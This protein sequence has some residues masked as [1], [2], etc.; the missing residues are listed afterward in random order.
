MLHYLVVPAGAAALAAC[1][2]DGTAEQADGGLLGAGATDGAA[3][4]DV[5]VVQLRVRGGQLEERRGAAPAERP[6]AARGRRADESGAARIEGVQHGHR[7]EGAAASHA[8]TQH[9]AEVRGDGA[10]QVQRRRQLQPRGEPRVLVA[11]FSLGG[12]GGRRQQTARRA[13]HEGAPQQRRQ[14]GA[15][16]ALPAAPEGG[17]GGG[18]GLGSRAEAGQRR[19]AEP[20]R[21]PAAER[22]PI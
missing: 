22:P 19:R 15:E 1:A 5:H 10:Q 14:G 3:A 9:H 4:V 7:A 12:G 13:E 6:S 16:A 21:L 11:L 20:S 8:R 2:D 17:G 18:P